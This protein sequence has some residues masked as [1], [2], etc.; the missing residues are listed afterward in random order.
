MNEDIEFLNEAA[1][2]LLDTLASDWPVKLPDPPLVG[3]FAED[4]LG[5]DQ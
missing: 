3:A 5:T 2:A 1:T 4:Q